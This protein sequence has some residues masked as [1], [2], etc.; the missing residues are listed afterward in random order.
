MSGVTVGVPDR[1]REQRLRAL[2]IANRVR[3]ERS[4]LKRDVKAGRVSLLA[5]LERPPSCAEGMKVLDVLLAAP[6]VGRSRST[7]W[8]RAAGVSPSRSL[9]GLTVRQ[10]AQLVRL[11]GG[12][13]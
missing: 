13:S 7:A 2:E 1:S 12:R 10:R 5:V 4:V 3:S 8:L 11:I 6:K 9:A